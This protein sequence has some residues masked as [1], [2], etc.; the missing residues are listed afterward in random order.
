[1]RGKTVYLGK[2]CHNDGSD[3]VWEVVTCAFEDKTDAEL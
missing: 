2:E 3:D 1:M